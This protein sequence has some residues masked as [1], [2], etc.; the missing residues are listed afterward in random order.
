[1]TELTRRFEILRDVDKWF[2]ERG[3]GLILTL[4]GDEYWAHLFPKQSLQI[5]APHY[6]RG[7]SPEAAAESARDR[8]KVE[9]EGAQV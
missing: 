1:V 3:F 4:D 6:G 7:P 8:Y 2:A 5:N 9:E